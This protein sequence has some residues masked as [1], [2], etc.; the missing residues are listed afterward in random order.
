MTFCILYR[1]TYGIMSGSRLRQIF[2]QSELPGR[3]CYSDQF[4]RSLRLQSSINWQRERSLQVT[5]HALKASGCKTC[6]FSSSLLLF[7]GLEDMK[8][9]AWVWDEEA[10]GVGDSSTHPFKKCTENV[11][12]T[13]NRSSFCFSDQLHD[14][15]GTF[16]LL[17]HFLCLFF[18]GL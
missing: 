10:T 4:G 11:W 5:S 8:M 12:S 13:F 9:V 18:P 1:T 2:S 7:M 17:S 6:L 3:L 15:R 14:F 16:K